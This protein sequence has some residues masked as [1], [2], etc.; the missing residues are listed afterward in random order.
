MEPGDKNLSPGITALRCLDLR[1][2]LDLPE[3]LV[4]VSEGGI[5]VNLLLLLRAVSRTKCQRLVIATQA[6]HG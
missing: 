5:M 1:L 2:A 4:H 3:P 6:S